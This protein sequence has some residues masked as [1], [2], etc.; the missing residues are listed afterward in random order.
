MTTITQTS[1]VGEAVAVFATADTLQAAIDEL[2]SSGFHRAE[3]SLLASEAEVVSKLGHKYRRPSELADDFSV[4]RAAYVSIEAIGDGQVIRGSVLLGMESGMGALSVGAEYVRQQGVTVDQ[5][6]YS[7]QPLLIIDSHGTLGYAGQ[8]GVPDGQFQVPAGNSLG[9]PPGRYLRLPGVQGQSAAAYRPFTREDSFSVAPFNY[10]QTPNE[11]AAFWLNGSKHVSEHVDVFVEGLYHH[12]DSSQ[13]AA[14]EQFISNVDPAPALADGSNGVPAN[15]YYNPFGVDLPYAA[16]RFVEAS[17]RLASQSVSIGRLVAGLEGSLGSR[18]WSVAAGYARGDSTARSQGAFANS[19]YETAL[20]PSGPTASGVI[21]CGTPDPL[22]GRVAAAD[23]IPDCVPLDIFNGAGSVSAAQLA[24][25]APRA[26]EDRGTNEQRFV[27]AVYSSQSA[28]SAADGPSWAAGAQYRREE[29]S[30]VGDPLRDL[31]YATLVDPSLPGG[32]FDARELFAELQLPA[33]R[34]RTGVP[35]AWLNLGARWSDFPSFGNHLSWEAGL[36]WQLAGSIAVRANYAT[37]FRA[38][39]LQDLY[40]AR[41]S[42]SE[43]D[44]DP[45][46]NKPSAA[47]RVHCAASGV[48]GGA[49]V[50]DDSEFPVISGGNP[51]LQPETGATL[52]AGAIYTPDWARG[53]SASLDW[54]DI[55]LSGVIGSEDAQ[56]L[57][58]Q[59]A[60]YGTAES[61]ASVHRLPDGRVQVVAAV[62]RNFAHRSVRG[63]DLAVDGSWRT[64]A[65]ELSVSLLATYLDRWDERPFDGAQTLEQAGRIDAGALPRWRGS[66]HLDWHRDR[67]RLGYGAQY[68]GSMSEEVDDFPPLGI[69]FAPY[70]R[71]IP[72]MIVHSLELHYRWRRG[73]TFN[74]AIINIADQDPPFVNLGFP[75]NTDPGTYPLLGREFSAGITW[76]F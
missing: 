38:P 52:G 69:V 63:V 45:C 34:G 41:T 22:T 62:N 50:Q 59:C 32:A 57:L 9:L 55:E 39:D 68:V 71:Q 66:L 64:Q 30:F 47:Q 13:Q 61:C 58:F 6:D 43:Y 33:L 46:G 27:E 65:G 29:G 54:Y 75:E 51:A 17:A 70:R 60:Q 3:L 23:V 2:L 31:G 44:F 16:R 15:N 25:M 37:V 8:S 1:G 48:P 21:A 10:S 42:A 4:P 20:G 19:R 73:L 28:A 24:Y 72:S 5:R 11:R 74:A 36:R 18:H 12:R 26:L 35:A 40:Q 49:Y 7:A 14:P 76:S 56:S 53:W 67:W